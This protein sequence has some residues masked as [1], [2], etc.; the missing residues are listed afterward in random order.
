MTPTKTLI[1]P[2]EYLHT[3]FEGLDREYVDGEIVERA[4]PTTSHSR[5]QTRFIQLFYEFEK[6]H[7]LFALGDLRHK[8]SVRRYRIPDVAVHH[9]QVPADEVPTEPPLVA[10]EIVSPEDRLTALLD[11]LEE[12]FRWGVPHVWLVDPVRREMAVYD[13]SGFHDVPE[14]TLPENGIS[15]TPQDVFGG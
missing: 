3:S 13:A 12:Y 2:E 7:L 15:F 14:L 8:L 9:G 5:V 11:K 6:S 1:T 10:I 4:M